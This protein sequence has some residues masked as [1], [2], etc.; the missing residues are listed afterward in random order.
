MRLSAIGIW[1]SMRQC[2]KFFYVPKYDI[3]GSM[4]AYLGSRSKGHRQMAKFPNAECG[5]IEFDG[6]RWTNRLPRHRAVS[7]HLFDLPHAAK[8][9]RHGGYQALA[10]YILDANIG[11][12]MRAP[13]SSPM[14]IYNLWPSL[15][16]NMEFQRTSFGF[17]TTACHSLWHQ[18]LQR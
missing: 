5:W 17:V 13:S 9:E 4:N 12:W 3:D 11:E 14:T 1:S 7:A 16:F 18:S 8:S 10:S 15:V 6:P 2:C